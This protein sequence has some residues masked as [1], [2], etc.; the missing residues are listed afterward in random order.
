MVY[1]QE[2]S[3]IKDGEKMLS[4]RGTST[5]SALFPNTFC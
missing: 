2:D 4:R 3:K 5:R 1:F